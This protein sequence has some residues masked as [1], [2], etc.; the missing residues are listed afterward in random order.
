MYGRYWPMVAALSAVLFSLVLVSACKRVEPPARQ[1]TPTPAATEPTPVA[2]TPTPVEPNLTRLP[3]VWF[4]P[5]PKNLGPGGSHDYMGLFEEEAPW[6]TAASHVQ[7][8]K[9]YGGWVSD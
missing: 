5:L 7:V 1:E 3:L 6:D 8:F 4:A 2:A 9:L